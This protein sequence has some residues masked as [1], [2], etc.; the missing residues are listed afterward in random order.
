MNL[1]RVKPAILSSKRVLVVKPRTVYS[2]SLPARCTNIGASLSIVDFS[3]YLLFACISNL[4]KINIKN[5]EIISETMSQVQ[6]NPYGNLSSQVHNALNELESSDFH[7]EPQNANEIFKL[8]NSV[9]IFFVSASGHVSTFSAPETLRIFKFHQSPEDPDTVGYFLQVGGWTH[10]LIAGASPCLQAENGA[11]MFPN[12]RLSQCCQV[13][14]HNYSQGQWIRGKQ[15]GQ[16]DQESCQ[17]S[18][19]QSHSQYIS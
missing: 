16:T 11:I 17:L 12:Q 13:R 1:S 10:P 18:C 2:A 8:E 9:Q 15:G 4:Q 3:F 7:Y 5:C 14:L 19:Q 6:N